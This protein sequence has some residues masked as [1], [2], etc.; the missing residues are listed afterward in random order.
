MEVLLHVYWCA[1]WHYANVWHNP[2]IATCTLHSVA[3]A[4]AATGETFLRIV[5]MRVCAFCFANVTA[6][7]GVIGIPFAV[8]LLCAVVAIHVCVCVCFLLR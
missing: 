2:K 5:C 4:V 1:G 6:Q 8:A 3:A 7:V